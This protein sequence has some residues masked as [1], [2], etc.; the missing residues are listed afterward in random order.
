MVGIGV[1][2]CRLIK[3][4]VKVLMLYTHEFEGFSKFLDISQ[5]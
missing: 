3:R 1:D 2:V 5:T 4:I